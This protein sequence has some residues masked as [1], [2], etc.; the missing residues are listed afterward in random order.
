MRVLVV[1]AHPDDEI[2]GPGGTILRH[3]KVGDEVTVL[4]GCTST[5]L[6]YGDAE[7]AE[8]LSVASAVAERM[9]VRL[10]LGDL[11]DQGL[12]VISLPKIVEIVDRQIKAAEAEVV[13]VHHW[14]DINRDHRILNEAVAVAARPYAAPGVR[15]IRC[16]ET[17]SAT[18]WGALNGLAPFVPNMFVDV[19]DTLD[20]KIEAFAQYHTEIRPAPHPRALQALADRSQFWGS[21]SGLQKAEPFVITRERW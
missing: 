19:S 15:A 11:P 3:V 10:V 17:P 8:L 5:N 21:I 13:Y 16:F 2:L 1:A 20:A 12:D 14:G 6:R 7:A 18:E 9:S 4:I